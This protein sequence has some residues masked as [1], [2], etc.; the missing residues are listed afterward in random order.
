L[1]RNKSKTSKFPSVCHFIQGDPLHPGPWQDQI[2]QS[3]VVINLVGK[4]IMTRWNEKT[5]QEIMDSRVISTRNVVQALEKTQDDRPCLINANAVGFY[6]DSGDKVYTEHDDSPGENFLAKV[7]VQWQNEAL[8]AKELGKRVI[9]AR[10]GAVLA[11]DGGVMAR[12]LPVFEKG[13]GGRISHGKQP[14]PWIHMNDLVR[15]LEFL[16]EHSHIHG[17][18]NLC[19]PHQT[20]NA[21]FTRALAQ[22]LRRPALFPVP[23]IILFLVFGELARM[24]LKSPRVKPQVLLDNRFTFHYPEIEQAVQNIV[25]S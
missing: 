8:K 25:K 13:L 24:L 15:G 9:I 18:V 23:G 21:D 5:K 6:P 1:I 7:C 10:F 16:A 14:F 3:D 22:T 20:S 17:P 19:A 2:R 12:V 4:N 11:R